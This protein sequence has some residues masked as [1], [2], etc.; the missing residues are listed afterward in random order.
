MYK[1]L[2]LRL[3]EQFEYIFRECT[4]KGV[5]HD[6]L[7]NYLLPMKVYF[8]EL[9]STD[10]NIAENGLKRFQQHLALFPKYFKG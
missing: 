7:H 3:M 6:Q 10:M 1:E 2:S 9:N 4:M 8:E 5:A